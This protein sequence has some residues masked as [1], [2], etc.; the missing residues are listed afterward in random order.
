MFFCT[1]AYVCIYYPL[2]SF[3]PRVV[4][5]KYYILVMLSCLPLI[6]GNEW[7]LAVYLLVFLKMMTGKKCCC[8]ISLFLKFKNKYI[9]NKVQ[10]V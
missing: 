8:L 10:I 9:F 6:P 7:K 5:V 1:L 2:S 4:P 3:T